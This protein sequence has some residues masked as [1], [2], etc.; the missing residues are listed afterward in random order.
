MIK[1]A[2]I[3]E[4]FT[5]PTITDNNS[6]Y[7]LHFP[8]FNT[9]SLWHVSPTVSDLSDAKQLPQG[10]KEF[11]LEQKTHQRRS[12]SSVEGG[13][14]AEN[15]SRELE[16]SHWGYP[17]FNG[18]EEK[19]EFGGDEEKMDM[20]WEDFNDEPRR[21]SLD[22]REGDRPKARFSDS[23]IQYEPDADAREMADLCCVQALK[24]SKSG[25]MIHHRRGSLLVI[26]KVLK[27]LFLIHSSHS[28]RRQQV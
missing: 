8:S 28:P 5:F 2:T 10:G 27:K 1:E 25:S 20:L 16:F 3:S 15:L 21:P 11:T 17:N 24:M 12:F 23:A 4:D 9:S 13:K 7:Q 22:K 18:D 14:K 19:S 6:L 26:L